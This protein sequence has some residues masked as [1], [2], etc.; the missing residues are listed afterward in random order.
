MDSGHKKTLTRRGW[1]PRPTAEHCGREGPYGPRKKVV[2]QKV[3]S[4]TR[5]SGGLFVNL[6]RQMFRMLGG[7]T[8]GIWQVFSVI[9]VVVSSQKCD[10]HEIHVVVAMW[11]SMCLGHIW[12]IYPYIYTVY[13]CIYY[14][15]KHVIVHI[16]SSLSRPDSAQV[17][18]QDQKTPSHGIISTVRHKHISWMI[19]PR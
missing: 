15:K 4:K 7:E 18:E 11:R 14:H 6:E 3:A 1:P 5:V 13:L 9:C 17:V 10:E 16:K 12:Y 8:V 2:V 19:S